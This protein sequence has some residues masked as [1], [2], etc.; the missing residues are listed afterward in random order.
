L[1]VRQFRVCVGGVNASFFFA[2]NQVFTYVFTE[3]VN[4]VANALVVVIQFDRTVPVKNTVANM[5]VVHYIRE[6]RIKQ[7]AVSCK[8]VGV[9]FYIAFIQELERVVVH[10]KLRRNK[11]DG[12]SRI[13]LRRLHEE[14][15]FYVSHEDFAEFN[16]ARIDGV[17]ENRS[18]DKLVI[19][20]YRYQ[21][22]HAARVANQY[23]V[24]VFQP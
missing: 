23:N 5:D 8:M 3:E 17:Y 18:F 10:R 16:D 20:A 4:N 7:V 15:V 11:G 22:S 12:R 6:H 21:S 2:V 14:N 24:F 19:F 9:M 13:R 1:A